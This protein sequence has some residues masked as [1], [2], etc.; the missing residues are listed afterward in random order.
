MQKIPYLFFVLLFTACAEDAPL[1]YPKHAKASLAEANDQ[2]P[3]AISLVNSGHQ[4]AEFQ[5]KKTQSF[6]IN[7]SN[8]DGLKAHLIQRVDGSAIYIRYASGSQAWWNSRDVRFLP[9]PGD[10]ISQEQARFDLRAWHYWSCLPYKLENPGTH[11]QA[12]P[13]RTLNAQACAVGRLTFDPGT[14]DTPKDWFAVFIGRENQLV[15]GAAYVATF[16]HDSAADAA[17]TPRMIRYSDYQIVERI[18]IAQR[19][20]FTGWNTDGLAVG[21]PLGEAVLS[22]IRFGG[23][24]ALLEDK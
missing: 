15:Q 18:P 14:G 13:D 24:E 9:A 6:D 21:A 16:G 2:S 7:W 11:W 22:N 1:E 10:T 8:R 20:S 17:K 23:G 3:E 19:W 12:L 4:K 5:E